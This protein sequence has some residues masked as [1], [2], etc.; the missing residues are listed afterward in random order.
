MV[1]H[2]DEW[3]RHLDAGEKCPNNALEEAVK[4]GN[5]I[6]QVMKSRKRVGL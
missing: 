2:G 5:T 1:M 3:H 6:T 4:A